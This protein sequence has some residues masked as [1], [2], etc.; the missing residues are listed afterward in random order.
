MGLDKKMLKHFSQLVE[1]NLHCLDF[2][3]A[4]PLTIAISLREGYDLEN[5]IRAVFYYMAFYN[6]SSALL[7]TKKRG[8]PS[9]YP[10]DTARRC[11]RGDRITRHLRS[12]TS[13]KRRHGSLKQW[14]IGGAG[15]GPT[16]E[17][18]TDR[19]RELYGNGRWATYTT[20]EMLHKV[21]GSPF[22]AP[23]TTGWRQSSGPRNGLIHLT[24]TDDPEVLDWAEHELLDIMRD[25]FQLNLPYY[26][27]DWDFG[28]LE[29][30]LCDFDGL[31]K[32]G[33]YPARNL[34][35]MLNRMTA[36]I[37]KMGPHQSLSLI[38]EARSSMFCH[39]LL[40]E[41]N[42][43]LEIDKKRKK[44]YNETGKVL[45]PYEDRRLLKGASSLQ[46]FLSNL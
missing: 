11:L 10:I 42:G 31:V 46:N 32:G 35:R 22:P 37:E 12:L 23:T 7:Y 44:H 13:M 39:D 28:I 9:K 24:G 45:C 19:L 33:Y 4:H 29:S 36:V 15:P 18:I 3:C 25:R 20:G 27:G 34:D 26:D 40:G 14:L 43:W 21:C 8:D 6:E 41:H 2:D 1:H 38:L 30:L 16:W 5:R 17:T